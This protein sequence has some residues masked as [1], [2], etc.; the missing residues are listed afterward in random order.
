M[1]HEAI[2]DQCLGVGRGIEYSKATHLGGHYQGFPPP[3][4]PASLY[5]TPLLLLAGQG[6]LGWKWHN[7]SPGE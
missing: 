7:V 6:P 2:D 3:S 5:P 4:L 1:P